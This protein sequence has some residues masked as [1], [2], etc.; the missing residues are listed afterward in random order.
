[1]SRG[2]GEKKLEDSARG[3]SVSRAKRSERWF[4]RT[5]SNGS[6][7]VCDTISERMGFG[8]I[9]NTK[10]VYGWRWLYKKKKK[11][12]KKRTVPCFLNSPFS[13]SVSL[14]LFGNATKSN[15]S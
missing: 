11:K 9:R 12:K 2:S 8:G 1:M 10:A 4:W 3:E 6:A 15:P 13:F 5:E 7:R 14:F